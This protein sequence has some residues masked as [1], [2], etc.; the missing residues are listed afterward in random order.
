MRTRHNSYCTST[1]AQ[2]RQQVDHVLHPVPQKK[3]W[4]ARLRG[5]AHADAIM[6]R[7]VHTATWIETGEVNTRA[8][9]GKA[10]E[11]KRKADGSYQGCHR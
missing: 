11:W 9:L 5:G 8:K 4:H 3:G 6:D 2:V 7:A 1:R 10:E